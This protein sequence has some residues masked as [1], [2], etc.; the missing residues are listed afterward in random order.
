MR[1]IVLLMLVV[2]CA[3]LSGCQGS[4][5]PPRFDVFGTVQYD[6]QLVSEGDIVF[7][8]EDGKGRPDGGNI[9]AGKFRFSVTA[10]KKRAEIRASRENPDK[11]IDSPMEPGKKVPARE[12]YIPDRY[13]TNSELKLEVVS[14]ENA[15][16][17]ELVGSVPTKS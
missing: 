2:G 9:V 11:L 5:A 3:V 1:S 14:G 10:G 12:D 15:I 16:D 4:N 8:P 7:L 6:G 17:F 13:N